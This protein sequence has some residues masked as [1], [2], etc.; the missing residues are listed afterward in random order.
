MSKI[1]EMLPKEMIAA[2]AA[3]MNS[4]EAA[5]VAAKPQVE[6]RP[7][8]KG[9][10]FMLIRLVANKSY[11]SEA[12]VFDS[13]GEAVEFEDGS[14][15]TFGDLATVENTRPDGS[16]GRHYPV[17][18]G[19]T[20]KQASGAISWLEGRP[21]KPKQASAGGRGNG[22]RATTAKPSQADLGQMIAAAVASQLAAMGVAP[23]AQPAKPVPV[24]GH[25]K[26]AAT[27]KASSN[28]VDLT[29]G[30]IVTFNGEPWQ[31]TVHANGRPALRKTVA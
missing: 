1:A 13:D 21:D 2:L 14:L 23:E 22:H 5:E 4:G 20:Q 24:P 18:W 31:V 3:M 12:V 28:T 17:V 15:V 30:Q 19:L 11:D 16:A 9:S 8:A 25:R 10:A 6:D 7:I 27:P 29:E 26:V